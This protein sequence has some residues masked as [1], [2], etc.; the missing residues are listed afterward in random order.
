MNER[1]GKT[2]R[3]CLEKPV[4]IRQ[5]IGYPDLTD[6]HNRWLVDM[7]C[8]KEDKTL[9]AHRGSYKTTCLGVAI[10]LNMVLRPTKTTL[11]M[12]KTNTDVEEVVRQVKKILSSDYVRAIAKNI[13]GADIFFTAANQ[14][15]LSTNLYTSMRGTPQLTGL[16]L[17]GSLT[18]KH[19][20]Y[21]FTDDIVNLQDRV[22]RAERNRTK[23]IYQELQNIKNR[24]GRIYNTGTPWHKDDCFSIMPAAEKYDCYST[25]LITPESLA[26]I[27]DSMSPSLFA[28]NYELRHIADEN[29]IFTDPHTG[30]EPALAMQGDSHIDASYGGEDYTAFSVV[31]KK[32]GKYYVFGKL[33]HKHV[34]DVT[35]EILSYHRAFAAGRIYCEL[36]ADKG[37]LAKAL[38]ARGERVSTYH[39]D[40][41]K[42]VKITS[43]LKGEW[44]NVYFVKGTDREYIEQ[45]TDYNEN[46]EHDD[47]PDSLR[48]MIRLKWK[49]KDKQRYTSVFDDGRRTIF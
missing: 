40:M 13:Y 15:E 39:E 36:N 25:G 9:Q 17:G 47:A 30:A 35:D 4:I 2:V 43:Y 34:D 46:A 26:R 41:N 20:D 7:L 1:A 33:W 38:R 49:R 42:Y 27:K 44:D 8:R 12:R 5:K 14:N 19:Y 45:I 23:L 31:N 24:G 16:G 29:L 6:L 22:S 48:S 18:G 10:R 3:L 21:I 11:F 32:D 37:Y 28:A